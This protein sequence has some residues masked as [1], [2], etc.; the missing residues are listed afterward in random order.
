V[1]ESETQRGSLRKRD[2]PRP[3]NLTDLRPA[4]I[5]YR[6]ANALWVPPGSI[7]IVD[8]RALDAQPIESGEY[9]LFVEEEGL[10]RKDNNLA[11]T[12]ENGKWYQR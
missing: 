11:L 7:E 8:V 6:K 12:K 4:V 5:E 1:S 3:S 9:W 10:Y 2:L